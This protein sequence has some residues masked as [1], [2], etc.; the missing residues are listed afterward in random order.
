M[1]SH[2][3]PRASIPYPTAMNSRC[4]DWFLPFY[5]ASSLDFLFFLPLL[6]F[7]VHV[8]TLGLPGY[9]RITSSCGH[10]LG[11]RIW[12]YLGDHFFV[13]L[14]FKVPMKLY[15]IYFNH[16]QKRMSFVVEW[17]L[18]GFPPTSADA[19]EFGIKIPQKWS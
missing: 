9:S 15:M 4:A 5:I 13:F 12:T 11:I 7:R 8:I 14:K 6:F 10:I 19:I 16:I 3:A 17:H 18:C 1:H 2:S